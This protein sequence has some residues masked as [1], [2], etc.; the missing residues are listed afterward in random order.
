[1]NESVK[2]TI[3]GSGRPADSPSAQ[4]LVHKDGR[5]VPAVFELESPAFLGDDDIAF[6]RYTDQAF[7]DQEMGQMWTRT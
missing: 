6:D 3:P 4:A 1:M 5:P 7:F 2:T